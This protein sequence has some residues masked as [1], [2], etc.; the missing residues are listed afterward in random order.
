[1]KTLVLDSHPLIKYFER[2]ENWEQVAEILQ[3]ASEDKCHLL[4]SVVNWG[5]IYY[6]THREYGQEYAEKVLDALRHMPVELREVDAEVTL[7]AARLKVPGGLS[8]ADCFAA[9]LARKK[10]CELVTGDRE[11]K[12]VENDVKIR[13]IK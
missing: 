12:Q 8:Y 1:M 5:E 6:I 7:E 4:L 10:K 3:E 9:A 13:W 11:F 2:E